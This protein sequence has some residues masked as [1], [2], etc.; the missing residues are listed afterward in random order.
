MAGFIFHTPGGLLFASGSVLCSISYLLGLGEYAAS[1]QLEIP[2]ECVRGAYRV[3][4]GRKY[5][6]YIFVV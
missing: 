3:Y 5:I 4:L 6:Y 2:T 1:K